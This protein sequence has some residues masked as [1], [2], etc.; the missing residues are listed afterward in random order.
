MSTQINPREHSQALS[1]GFQVGI[2]FIAFILVLMIPFLV[3]AEID[4]CE[5]GQE[6]K[7]SR[8]WLDVNSRTGMTNRVTQSAPENPDRL[9]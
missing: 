8:F 7:A 6:L 9:L 1:L 4:K 5:S 3:T 2:V